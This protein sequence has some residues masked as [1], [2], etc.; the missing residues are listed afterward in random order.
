MNG[1]KFKVYKEVLREICD[2]YDETD[3]FINEVIEQI[4]SHRKLS[5]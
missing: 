1:I 4:C 5:V 3:Y 2:K